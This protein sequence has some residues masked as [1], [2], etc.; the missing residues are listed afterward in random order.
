MRKQLSQAIRTTSVIA[1]LLIMFESEKTDWEDI[2]ALLIEFSA[3]LHLDV[4][5]GCWAN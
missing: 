4:N 5:S 3:F 2:F 1:G